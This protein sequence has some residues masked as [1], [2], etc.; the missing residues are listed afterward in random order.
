[1]P[2]SQRKATISSAW[3]SSFSTAPCGFSSPSSTSSPPYTPTGLWCL[4]SWVFQCSIPATAPQVSCTLHSLLQSQTGPG[5]PLPPEMGLALFCSVCFQSLQYTHVVP[6][7]S[8]LRNLYKCH[9]TILNYQYLTPKKSL[10]LKLPRGNFFV[11]LHFDVHRVAV[12]PLSQSK[13]T[14][15]RLKQLLQPT[16]SIFWGLRQLHNFDL[17]SDFAFSMVCVIS[18]LSFAPVK[19]CLSKTSWILHNSTRIVKN[20][21]A[22]MSSYGVNKDQNIIR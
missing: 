9:D 5:T 3:S 11:S 16:I 12:N 20:S 7:V 15:L 21:D 8:N 10:L 22:K 6:E 18:C 19:L 4:D 2:I 14:T 1:M 13:S 17:L